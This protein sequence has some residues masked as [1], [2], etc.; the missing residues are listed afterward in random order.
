MPSW[1]WRSEWEVQEE[2]IAALFREVAAFERPTCSQHKRQNAD[3][4]CSV[5]FSPDGSLLASAG[6]AK[7]VRSQ[8]LSEHN[9][10]AGIVLPELLSS[11]SSVLLVKCL[12]LVRLLTLYM[13]TATVAVVGVTACWQ[14][15]CLLFF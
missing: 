14:S 11:S 13:V 5:E 3:I 9:I 6:V 10:G 15:F 1:Q 8:Q 7:Q 4:V 2:P 12:E